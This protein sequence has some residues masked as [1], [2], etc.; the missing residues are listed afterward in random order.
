MFVV[1]PVVTQSHI[2][3]GAIEY[4]PRTVD[5]FRIA[6][7]AALAAKSDIS[8]HFEEAPDSADDIEAGGVAIGSHT[9]DPDRL[10]AAHLYDIVYIM[11]IR[12][13]LLARTKGSQ[14]PI[15]RQRQSEP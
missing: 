6:E 2:T 5:S 10:V 15:I 8:V 4:S 11:L 7:G 14:V 3:S 12:T 9:Y 1:F 13:Y